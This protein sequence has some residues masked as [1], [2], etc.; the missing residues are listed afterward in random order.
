M[1]DT[2]GGSGRGGLVPADATHSPHAM[3]VRGV[4]RLPPAAI[5]RY[6]GSSWLGRCWIWWVVVL[7]SRLGDSVACSCRHQVMGSRRL[8]VARRP[9]DFFS[10]L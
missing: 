10:G 6:R 7:V 8:G 2:V 3:Q 4:S 1:I 9:L 5:L